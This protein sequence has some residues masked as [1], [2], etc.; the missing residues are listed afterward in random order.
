[1]N[2]TIMRPSYYLIMKNSVKTISKVCGRLEKEA[3]SI[4]RTPM[5]AMDWGP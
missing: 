2:Y 5:G 3:K 4:I 1:M